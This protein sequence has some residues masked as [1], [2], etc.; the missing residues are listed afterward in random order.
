[1][2]GYYLIG[3]HLGHSFSADI[4]RR[5]GR[6]DYALKELSPA[7]L[8]PFLERR[9]FTGL[10]VTIPY[11]EAVIPYLDRLDEN[12]AAIGAVNTVVNRDGVLWGY[13]TDFG[14]M[15]A[16]LCRLS[17]TRAAE[18][19]PCLGRAA[20]DRPYSASPLSLRG[21]FANWPWQ[22]VPQL[23]QGKTVLILGTGGTSKTA[24]AVCRALGA[25]ELFRVS[26]T[27]REG[28][29]RY[30]QA[31]ALFGVTRSYPDASAGSTDSS[32][33]LRSAQN[34]RNG[35]LCFGA[36]APLVIVNCTP[37]GMRPDP[38]SAPISLESFLPCHSERSEES[39]SPSC[40]SKPCPERSRRSSEE[41]V[42]FPGL[43]GVFDCVYNPLRTRLVLEAQARGIPAAGGL[44]MLVKQAA[45]ACELFTGTP[46]EDENVD[47]I[48]NSLRREQENIVLIGMPGAGKTTV[49][50]I[51]AQKTGKLFVDTD[52]A[53][54]Q[55]TGKAISAIFAERGEAGFR[56]LEAAV[57]R[58]LA[59]LSGRVVATGG[60]TVL[61]EENV[62]LLKHYG[63]LVFL[64]RPLEALEPSSERPLGDTAEKLRKLYAERCPIYRAAADEIVSAAAAPEDTV[65]TMLE[66]L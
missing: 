20:Y 8:G 7:E 5:F 46:V 26:R 15:A 17:E 10:N 51:L 47:I 35:T 1:M 19:R 14:G 24:L 37:V 16:A 22:S 42:P 33:P 36:A 27:G 28:A 40:H 66:H 60:G 13:N 65:L 29:L 4:H 11:K 32:T 6:Y 50:R 23:L 55:R 54:V 38:E 53:L 64:D 31:F 30:K 62:R 2:N 59:G 3:E 9:D 45:L 18:C 34:D 61:R 56:E 25:A 57:V 39:V 48:H 12:A 52:E 41:P 58:E 21:Q 49:G 43:S 44:Y 63:R